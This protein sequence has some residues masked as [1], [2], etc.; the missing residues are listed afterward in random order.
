MPQFV[1]VE[2]CRCGEVFGIDGATHAVLKR[3]SKG[4]NCPFGHPLHYPQGKSKEEKLQE[5]LDRE[6]RR[7]QSAEQN[8]AY[9]ADEAKRERHRANGYKGHATRIS[10]RVKHGVCPC[11]NRTFQDL[12]RHMASKHPTFTPIDIEQGAPKG[13][14]VQ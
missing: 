10:R 5:E 14:T 4:F 2:C 1:S 12:A 6:R 7:R 3:S 13:A 8:V 9:Y 11:C